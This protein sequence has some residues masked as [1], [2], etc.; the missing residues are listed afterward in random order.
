M[1]IADRFLVC[2]IARQINER[3]IFIRYPWYSSF[4]RT[5]TLSRV[6][7]VVMLYWAFHANFPV[8]SIDA[9]SLEGRS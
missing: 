6:V 1:R 7:E 5:I 8:G 4:H 2:P 3:L 9:T